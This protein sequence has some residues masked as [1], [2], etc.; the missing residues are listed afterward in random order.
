MPYLVDGYNLA[1]ATPQFESGSSSLSDKVVRFLNR[2]ARLRRTKVTVVFDGYPPGCQRSQSLSSTFDAVRIIFTGSEGDA[3]TKIRKMIATT[4]NQRG[5][6]V[7]STDHAVH[8]YARSS[9]LKAIRSA[10]FL[11]EANSLLKERQEDE[12]TV[13]P[14]EMDYWM[15]VFSGKR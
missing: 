10:D 9:G 14:G 8:G 3:D 13:G 5:L 7:I 11:R 1:K 6:T 15:K 12:I 4:Q 2:F